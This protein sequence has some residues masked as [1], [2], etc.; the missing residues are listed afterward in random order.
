MRRKKYIRV[1]FDD[2]DEEKED[3]QQTAGERIASQ[4]FDVKTM[5]LDLLTFFMLN[6]LECV[7]CLS[8]RQEDDDDDERPVSSDRHRQPAREQRGSNVSDD[9]ETDEDDFIVDDRGEPIQQRRKHA[10]GT[11]DANWQ[12]AQEIFGLGFDVEDLE[13]DDGDGDDD[14]MDGDDDVSLA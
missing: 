2:S 6:T 5:R 4:L 11:G 9:D 8:F 13:V 10:A 3:K 14:D 12:E 1:H 7:K